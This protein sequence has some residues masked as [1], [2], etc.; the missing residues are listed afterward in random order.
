MGIMVMLRGMDEPNKLVTW[1]FYS[2]KKSTK[3]LFLIESK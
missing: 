3:M 1:V 2:T